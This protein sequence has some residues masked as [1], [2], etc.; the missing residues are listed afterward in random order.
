MEVQLSENF[1][2]NEF[3]SSQTA[4]RKP[5]IAG[6]QFNPQQE[7]IENLRHLC[8]NSVQPLRSL[9]KTPMRISSGYRSKELNKAVGGAAKSRH[10]MG[11]AADIVLSDRLIRDEELSRQRDIV[12][13]MVYERIGLSLRKDVNANFYLFALACMYINELDVDQI[14]HEY[15]EHGQPAWVHISSSKTRNARQILVLPRIEGND[16]SIVTMEQALKLGC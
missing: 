5:E 16:S 2:L 1:W 11:E 10:C 15:G 7:V 3:T 12:R 6:D 4:T 13:N 8:E 14:I 9:L